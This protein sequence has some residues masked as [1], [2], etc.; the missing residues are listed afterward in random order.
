MEALENAA[1]SHSPEGEGEIIPWVYGLAIR[2][3]SGGPDM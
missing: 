1:K 3:W 2:H